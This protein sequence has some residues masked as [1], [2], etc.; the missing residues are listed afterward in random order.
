MGH[1]NRVFAISLTPS[2]SIK[3]DRLID[4][5]VDEVMD[6]RE[7]DKSWRMRKDKPF[8]FVDLTALE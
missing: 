4:D 6:E 2:V 7:G 8:V 3:T 5:I 1:R